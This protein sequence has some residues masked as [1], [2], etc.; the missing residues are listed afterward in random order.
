MSSVYSAYPFS[1]VSQSGSQAWNVPHESVGQV[2]ING[3][4]CGCGILIGIDRMLI[5]FHLISGAHPNDLQITFQ[6][7]NDQCCVILTFSVLQ[8]VT[9]DARL[10]Y[11]I[12]RLAEDECGN[13]PGNLLDFPEVSYDRY[14]GAFLFA[15]SD[16]MIQEGG[17]PC[18]IS[19]FCSSV[20][21]MPGYSGSGYFDPWGRLFA[22]H[23][24]RA[25]GLCG[26]D[27]E[28]RALYLCEI[29]HSNHIA[30]Q[31]LT[32]PPCTP[33]DAPVRAQRAPCITK[34]DRC[35]SDEGK[36][37]ISGTI[38]RG[39]GDY[40]Y[41]ESFP[42]NTRGAGPRGIEI[43]P[44]DARCKIGYRISQNPHDFKEYIKEPATLYVN[45]AAAYANLNTTPASPYSKNFSFFAYGQRFDAVFEGKQNFK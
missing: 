26:P 10:D 24:S 16:T 22:M 9:Y 25:T 8:F 11:C 35:N 30:A 41:W 1:S 4:D 20:E 28:R 40:K 12:L 34:L 36:P 39:E 21:S 15:S 31:L 6:Q 37:S 7:D 2:Q 23:L 42:N 5:P 33:L 19:N 17:G 29:A 43:A 27:N 18:G 45:A 3:R 38:K 13:F 14:D 32:M 44:P